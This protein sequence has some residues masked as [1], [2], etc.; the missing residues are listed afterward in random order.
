MFAA[1]WLIETPLMRLISIL[2]FV[3]VFE[4]EINIYN[5]LKY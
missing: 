3:I 1:L 5:I 2:E 4:Y